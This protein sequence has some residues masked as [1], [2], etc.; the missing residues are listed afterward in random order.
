MNENTRITDFPVL[1]LV[2]PLIAGIAGLGYLPDNSG[3]VIITSIVLMVVSGLVLVLCLI[4]RGTAQFFF[5]AGVF[6]LFFSAGAFSHAL[7]RA[8]VMVEWPDEERL[9]CGLL[10]DFPKEKNN[11]YLCQLTL[12]EKDGDHSALNYTGKRVYLYIPKDTVVVGMVP[13]QS[14]MFYGKIEKPKS[15]LTSFDYAE[16][17]YK[18]GV[19]GTLWV[20]SQRWRVVRTE[21]VSSYLLAALKLRQK[22]LNL[23]S[24]WGIPEEELSVISAITLGYKDELSTETREKYSKS[25]AS[26]VLAVSGLHV[27]IMYVILS[28]LFPSFMN[29]GKLRWIKELLILLLLWFYAVVIGM[30]VSIVRSLIMFS[31]MALGKV[32]SRESSSM[33]SLGLAALLI[34]LLDPVSLYQ[35]SFQLSF[36][37]VFFIL[38]LQKKFAGLI[39]FKTRPGRYINDILSVSMAAQVGTAPLVFYYFSSF[40]TYFLITNLVV[41][42]LMFIVVL[43][44]MI[45]WIVAVVPFIRSLV[46]LCL[47]KTVSLV[48]YILD[49]ISQLPGS[50]LRIELFSVYQVVLVYFIILTICGYVI[51]KRSGLLIYALCFAAVLSIVSLISLI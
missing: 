25:G 46:V 6:V 8:R 4:F 5:G 51:K 1:R 2:I 29:R 38:L 10:S 19:S 23:Y 24:E 14:L 16:Y 49:N 36:S 44:S 42:P 41:I 7:E 50:S 9:Y 37:A 13:G 33:N 30:P 47:T 15:D 21:V 20:N 48:N 45:L 40:S 26:H 11:S 27:G 12:L 28:L 32:L 31:M 39:K 22:M 17:L 35:A 34:L 43:L 18:C 3:W